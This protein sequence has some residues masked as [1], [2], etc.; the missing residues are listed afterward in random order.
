M[1]KMNSFFILKIKLIGGINQ[2]TSNTEKLRRRESLKFV[3][4]LL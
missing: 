2:G 4:G 1:K 3:F